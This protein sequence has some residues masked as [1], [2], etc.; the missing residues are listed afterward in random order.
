HPEARA[1][2]MLVV[3][4]LFWGLSFPLM[5]NWQ[6][7]AGDCPGGEVVSSLSLMGVRVVLALCF[8]GLFQRRL[9]LMPTRREMGLGALVVLV[10]G[11]GNILQVVGLASTTPALSGFFT[12]LASV[13]VPIVAFVLFRVFSSRLTLIGFGLAIVGAAILG[14]NF[15]EA[16]GLGKGDALTLASSLIFAGEILMLDRLG[17]RIVSSHLT[18]GLISLT[19]L[20]ALALAV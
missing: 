20:P 16:W 18:I 19:G 10:N 8:L 11:A 7:A 13:W 2:L 14:V 4:T 3:A 12:S 15:D 17:K 6:N 9:F 1:A 5:K